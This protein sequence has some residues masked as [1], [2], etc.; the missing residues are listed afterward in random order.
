M[1]LFNKNNKIIHFY[2]A[3]T[4]IIVI[5]ICLSSLNSPFKYLIILQDRKMSKRLKIT[6]ET[7][8]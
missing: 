1:N 7:I 6:R 4:T 2:V 3:L 5:I 8:S